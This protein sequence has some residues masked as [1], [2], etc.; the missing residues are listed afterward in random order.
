MRDL[1]AIFDFIES[2]DIERACF[3]HLVPAGR[4]RAVTEASHEEVRAAIDKIFQRT[5]EF[6]RSGRPREILTVDNHAD[7]VYA[8]LKICRDEPERAADV[9]S[10]LSWNGGAA[11]STGRG[12]ADID[13]L[14]NVHPDQFLQQITFGN[15]R[16]RPFSEIWSDDSNETLHAL[17]TRSERIQGRCG[18]CRFFN[19]CGGN[20][21]ARAFAATGSLWASDPGCYL[22]DTEIHTLAG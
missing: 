18:D 22:S 2:E 9:Y 8:Y 21:R 11:N 19:L 16:N 5:Q 12:I 10:T 4:G 17:R 20:F 6:A 3:Y 13:W 14:G 15:V 7:A 1:D